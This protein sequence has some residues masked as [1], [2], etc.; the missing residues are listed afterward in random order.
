M[1]W[2]IF[3]LML[4]HMKPKCIKFLVPELYSVLDVL[5]IVS[6][7]VLVALFVRRFIKEKK[8]PSP[9]IWVLAALEGWICLNTLIKGG[10][11]VE[12]F[13]IAVSAMGI[14]LLVDYFSDRMKELLTSLM[15]NFEWLV[16]ANLVTVLM[17]PNG[18]LVQDPAYNNM[19]IYFF[20]ADNGMM[21]L[22]IPAVCVALLYLRMQMQQNSL[23]LKR[24]N[25]L[26][27][28]MMRR[29]KSQRLIHVPQMA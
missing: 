19:P 1:N 23:L 28:A 18:G 4:P 11:Y 16:Y 2:L 3:V 27:W 17:Y 20:D 14:V 15:L 8:L 13:S 21:Y 6:L 26:R 25:S 10:D 29:K 7:L 24:E 9:L 12:V 22:C 5:R